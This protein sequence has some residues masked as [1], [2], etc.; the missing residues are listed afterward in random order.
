M[1]RSTATIKAGIMATI[2]ADPL[3]GTLLTSTSLTSLFGLM[4]YVMAACQN[5]LEQSW[6]DYLVQI[7]TY[8]TQTP[9]ASLNWVAAQAF[10]FQYDPSGNPNTNNLN[11]LSNGAL[12]YPDVAP[13]YNVVSR[14]AAITTANNEVQIKVAQGPVTTPAQITG[15]ALAQLQSYFDAKGTAGIIYTVTSGDPDLIAIYG[16]VYYKA[17]YGGVVQANVENALNNYLNNIAIFDIGSKEPINY[18]GIVKVSEII[19]AVMSAEGV[20][21][22]ELDQLYGRSATTAFSGKT[23]VYDLGA[24]YTARSYIL[25]AGYAIGETSPNNWGL[26][27]GYQSA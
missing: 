5:L 8:A 6:D 12:G 19:D 26:T 14:C 17:G 11:I 16:T 23:T 20:D 9:A 18:Q 24:G 25:A 1:A 7:N 13:Q 22:F 10:L 4:A 3:L 15:T 21:D 2:A 27:I